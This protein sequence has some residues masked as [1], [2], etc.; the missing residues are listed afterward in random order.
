MNPLPT[1][2]KIDTVAELTD[3]L[4]R[5]QMALVADYRGLT[6]AEI[7]DLRKQLR[8]SG[9][10]LIVAKNTLVSLAAKATGREGLEPLLAGPTAVA[11][12]YD[13]VSGAAKAINDF[14]KGAKQV[15]V[16]GGILGNSMLDSSALDQVSKLPSRQQ[17]LADI[18]GGVQSPLVG[19]VGALNG[20]VA[21][22]MYAV[23]ARIDQL[24][25]AGEQAA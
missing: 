22:V 1:Q 18:V 24:Q 5:A 9:A 10:E 11:F 19:V 13:D 23:Q 16:R 12:A 8:A 2:S 6:V 7:S 20:V 21:N 14:N 4:S 17:V 25:P 15:K 3:K